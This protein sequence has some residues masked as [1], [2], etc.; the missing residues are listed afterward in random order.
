MLR[1][2]HG[3]LDLHGIAQPILAC[4]HQDVKNLGQR[5]SAVLE[6]GGEGHDARSRPADAIIDGVIVPG[7]SGGQRLQCAVALGGVQTETLLV[8]MS[9]TAVGGA[10]QLQAP[11]FRLRVGEYVFDRGKL[12]QVVG[13]ARA[14]SQTL[15]AIHH[16]SAQAQSDGGDAVFEGHRRHGIII[17]R[18]H[19]S[20][21]I[22]IEARPVARAHNLLENHRHFFFFQAIRRRPHV[23]LRMAAEGGG[24]DAPDGLAERLQPGVLIYFR[25]CL[26]ICLLVA[27]H[28]GF[29]HAGERLVLRIL[30]QT[31]GANRQGMAYLGQERFQVFGERLGE[32]RG[33][34]LPMDFSVVFAMQGKVQEVV[35]G[36]ELIEHIRRQDDGGRHRDANARKTAGDTALA[37]EV[38]DKGEAASFPTERPGTD[39]QK[40]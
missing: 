6:H 2:P 16:G 24:V 28:E 27:Q 20:G 14:E 19:D 13:I 29:I 36:D 31:G 9:R 8:P 25:I 33:Q 23:G 10:M 39:A 4:P 3:K 18:A 11:E 34:E 17:A 30:Q 15:P 12:H 22:G 38:A 26:R 32:R 40:T 1:Q 5:E 37:Q 7:I 21:E 35:L